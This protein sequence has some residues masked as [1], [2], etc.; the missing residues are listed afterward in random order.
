MRKCASYGRKRRSGEY[1]MMQLSQNENKTKI[2]V[3]N[4]ESSTFV[5]INDG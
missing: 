2:G 5:N 1:S 4:N 3:N